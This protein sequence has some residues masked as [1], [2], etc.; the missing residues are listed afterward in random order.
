[1]KPEDLDRFERRCP[2]LGGPV[3]FRYCLR[4]ENQ[5]KPCHKTIDCWW[6]HF[7]VVTFLKEHLSEKAFK[8]LT[9]RRPMNKVSSLVDLIAQARNRMGGK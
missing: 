9:E 7:D 2:R 6:E 8:A 4:A 1:M 5:G 3:S